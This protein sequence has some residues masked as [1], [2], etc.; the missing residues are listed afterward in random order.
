[1]VVP[2]L[3]FAAA[4]VAQTPPPRPA[5]VPAAAPDA[6]TAALA[7]G[8]NAVAAGRFDQ[9]VKTADGL[10]R[11][12]AWDHGAN[13]LRI[14]ALAR[15]S[16]V[17]GLD[18]YEQWL[19]R[20]HVDEAAMLEP[21][22][23]AFLQAIVSSPRP[24]LR[25]PALR[26]LTLNG[27]VGAREALAAEGGGA[28]QSEID[29][30]QAKSGDA[31]AQQRLVERLKSSNPQER[32]AAAEALGSSRSDAVHA[33]LAQMRQDP[34]PGVRTAVSVSLAEMGDTEALATVERML[35]T[36]VPDVQIMASRAY[37]GRPGPWVAVVRPL[38]DNPDG[39]T[40]LD[41]AR[42]IAPVDPEAARKT[43]AAALRDGNPVIRF[44][45]ARVFAESPAL[46][47]TKEDIVTLRQR[48]R[49]TDPAVRMAVASALLRLARE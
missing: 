23:I 12:R 37:G 2:V 26:A 18:A 48:L 28:D 7:A 4:L 17:R 36:N 14:V 40:R 30:A 25:T 32:A 47:L 24:E 35:S 3:L 22:A 9:A 41:A 21:V 39:T 19:K 6:D 38:L 46:Q 43:L 45:S 33:A 15:T 8:W 44:E 10:L 34:D 42:A 5:A 1:M 27:V 11:R 16:P 49:D 20:A 29:A 31:A 13:L